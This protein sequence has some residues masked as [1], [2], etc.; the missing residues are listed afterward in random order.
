MTEEL[1]SIAAFLASDP[2]TIHQIVERLGTATT[3]YGS[4]ILITPSNTLFLEANVVRQVSRTT[5]DPINVLSHVDLTPSEPPSVGE[6]SS[7]F[8]KYHEAPSLHDDPP[9]LIFY[10]EMHGQPFAVTL[11][12][13]IKED[14][15]VALTFRRDVRLT[16]DDVVQERS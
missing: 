12:A 13:Q 4:N 1:E 16:D 5:L 3:D 7:A 8:G 9:E 14:R 6:L 2:L 10:L 11:I 15:A